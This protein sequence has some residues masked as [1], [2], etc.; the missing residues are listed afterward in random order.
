MFRAEDRSNVNMW[1]KASTPR[2]NVLTKCQS[3]CIFISPSPGPISVPL[4]TPY[5]LNLEPNEGG[6]IVGYD[7]TTA[8]SPSLG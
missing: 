3:G 8:Q 5:T 7:T 1:S 4:P 2:N 6:R